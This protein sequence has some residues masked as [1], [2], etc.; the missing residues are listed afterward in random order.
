[1]LRQQF[2]LTGCQIAT[3]LLLKRILIN[4][5]DL[6]LFMDNSSNR[7]SSHPDPSGFPSVKVNNE[8]STQI[9]EVG[10][11]EFRFSKS[12]FATPENIFLGG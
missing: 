5:R 4:G 9:M 2:I 12:G 1:V 10:V 7:L 8:R 3:G 11:E 6:I